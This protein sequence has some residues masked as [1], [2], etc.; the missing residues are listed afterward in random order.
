MA[1]FGGWSDV[2][3]HLSYDQLKELSDKKGY[4]KCE[5]YDF[6]KEA[7][8]IGIKKPIKKKKESD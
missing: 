3:K 4:D 1:K 8:K 5:G 2:Y 6:D 7:K